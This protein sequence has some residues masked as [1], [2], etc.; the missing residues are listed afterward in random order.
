MRQPNSKYSNYQDV[1]DGEEYD[2]EIGANAVD[3][4]GNKIFVTYIFTN[5]KGDG[6][7]ELDAYDYNAPT[8]VTI[9]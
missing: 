6:A 7:I 3:V 2:F 5:V 8:N 1:A 4:D 9:L